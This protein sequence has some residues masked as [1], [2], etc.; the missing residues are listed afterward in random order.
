MKDRYVAQLQEERQKHNEK[1]EEYKKLTE[2]IEAQKK[3]LYADFHEQEMEYDR[4]IRN[5]DYE[6]K[7][8]QKEIDDIDKEIKE[9]DIVLEDT[10]IL[11][12][13]EYEEQQKL[14]EKIDECLRLKAQYTKDYAEVEIM[15]S[16]ARRV[17]Y[18]LSKLE[19]QLEYDDISKQDA[20]KEVKAEGLDKFIQEHRYEEL[21]KLNELIRNELG[22]NNINDD[23]HD[24]I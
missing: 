24:D 8:K 19:V 10:N 1:S 14:Q 7:K 3:E 23:G 21:S 12:Q 15:D 22:K 6:L 13:M 5:K 18:I 11:K 17:T 4:Q 16:K 2:E 20:L 9:T